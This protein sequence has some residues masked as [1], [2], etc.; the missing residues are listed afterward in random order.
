M[1]YFRKER[2][3]E[4]EESEVTAV[5]QIEMPLKDYTFVKTNYDG[6]E[7]YVVRI[8]YMGE[9]VVF[10]LQNEKFEDFLLD[11]QSMMVRKGID[12]HQFN[13][14]GI[15]LNQIFNDYISPVLDTLRT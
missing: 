8:Q 6:L 12:D 14:I 4:R 10:D 13:D 3:I 11:Y 2:I 15:R 5:I 7:R 9:D 1:K